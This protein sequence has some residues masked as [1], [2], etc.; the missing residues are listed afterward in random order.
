MHDNFVYVGKGLDA[1]VLLASGWEGWADGATFRNNIFFA[2]GTARY[3]HEVARNKDGTY[4]I[5]AGWGLA[6][7][8]VFEGNRYIGNQID[9]P[10][11]PRGSY[12]KSAPLASIDWREPQFD[13]AHPDGFDVFLARHRA[14]MMRTFERQ[15]RKPVRLGR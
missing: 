14:W 5:A 12:A 7:N 4:E 10:S 8:I 6:K 9:A 3:G 15:F 2:D 1:Q 11:D 13:P